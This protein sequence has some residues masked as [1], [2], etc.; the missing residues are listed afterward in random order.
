[1]HPSPDIAA[2][3]KATTR[4]W[5]GLAVLALACLMYIMDL[6]VLHLAV[7]AMS[8]DL[9][10]TSSQLLWIIDI[11]GFMVAGFLITMGTLGDRIGRRRL[12][13]IGSA[14]FGV[15]SLLCAF[16]TSAEMLILSRALLGIAGATLAPS[17]LSLLFSMFEDPSQRSRAIAIWV[18]AFSAGSAVGPLAGGFV[19][20]HFWWGAVF[21]L[22]I[23]VVIL[24]L[25]LG[26]IVLPEYRDPNAGR[27]DLPS[28]F[29]SLVA[30]LAVIFGLKEIAQGGLSP[31]AIGS[32]ALG[33]VVGAVWVRR[34]LR[35]TDPMIDLRLLRGRAFSAALSVNFLTVFVMVGYFLFVAQYLQLVLGMSPLEA[36]AWS[37]PSAIAF[38]IA[39]NSVPWLQRHFGPERI[40]ATGF[41]VT[42]IGLA[43]LATASAS[44]DGLVPVV[45]AS[46]VIS[47][48]LGPIFGLT[49]ELVV[50]SAPPEK[51]GAASG[52]SETATELGASM[53]IAILGSI[54]VA[55]YR[56][57]M[58]GEAPAGIP[59]EVLDAA[60]DTLGGAV[61]AAA[62][63]PQALGDALLALAR[64]SFVSSMQTVAI[65]S[66]VLAVGAAIWAFIAIRRPSSDDQADDKAWSPGTSVASE[67]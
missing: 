43:I 56:S 35:L 57:T 8:A 32:M 60:R 7:P 64:D 49:T 34:Q 12:L 44:M 33:V 9:Q 67:A 38:I 55:M 25:V 24:L 23:P 13:L 30:V 11:Y 51:A 36:G 18:S 42:A 58:L 39:S 40:I 20:E 21:L 48:G 41:G 3:R 59:R 54:G 14:A 5:V 61:E 45:V 27:L 17:T 66:A 15:A 28:A 63:L 6:T 52:I 29:M 1:M 50:G 31:V 16:S 19:L 10:P 37:V 53:G 65:V 46:I 62:Q 22:A 47:F 26:P 4:E 2:P